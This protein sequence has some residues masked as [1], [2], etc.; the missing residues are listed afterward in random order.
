MITTDTTWTLNE[1]P[2][3]VTCDVIVDAG[4]TLTIEP[5]VMVQ[6][7]ALYADLIISGTLQAA[8]TE[9]APIHFNPS[10]NT[11]PGSWGRV[12]FMAGSSGV[13]DHTLL[14]YGG[15]SEGMVYIAS[16]SVQ[17]VDSVVQYS[18]NTGIY[19][20]AASPLISGTQ[21]LTNTTSAGGGGLFNDTGSPLIQNNTFR[22]NSTTLYSYGGGGGLY[23]GC[24]SPT[25]QNNRFIGN[26]SEYDSPGGGLYNDCGKPVIQNNIFAGNVA[27]GHPA[28]QYSIGN[29][30]G[31][32]FSYGE[33]VI[34]NNIFTGNTAEFAA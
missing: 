32:I 29:K 19:I 26:I 30:G 21:I 2:I 12:A 15:S 23:N 7:E 8:G 34:L 27:K 6:F 18:A 31:G 14:E 17:V 11:T 28:A 13:L 20:H 10:S 1:S 22:N 25:I 33:P 3:Q 4:V 9:V 16:D 24:G 5:G